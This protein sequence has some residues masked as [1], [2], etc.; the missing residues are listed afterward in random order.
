MIAHDLKN[1][2]PILYPYSNLLSLFILLLHTHGQDKAHHERGSMKNSGLLTSHWQ[3]LQGISFPSSVWACWNEFH[4]HSERNVTLEWVFQKCES[5]CL[6]TRKGKVPV[7]SEPSGIVL[8]N[9]GVELWNSELHFLSYL[10]N[11]HAWQEVFI[12]T[13][14]PTKCVC[15]YLS[16]CFHPICTVSL[17]PA[18]KDAALCVPALSL[19]CLKS[20][21]WASCSRWSMQMQPRWMEINWCDILQLIQNIGLMLRGVLII[22]MKPPSSGIPLDAVFWKM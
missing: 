20:W 22:Q 12:S 4:A 7:V 3:N 13:S 19:C 14:K 10:L 2:P 6:P 5:V 15:L 17:P 8:C 11:M 21:C 1:Q 16:M 9:L 18:P